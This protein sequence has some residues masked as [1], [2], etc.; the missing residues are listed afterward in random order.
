MAATKLK[1]VEPPKVVGEEEVK[2]LREDAVIPIH[3]V[4]VPDGPL[5]GRDNLLHVTIY[6]S[7]T[8]RRSW[9]IL[10]QNGASRAITLSKD[11]VAELAIGAIPVAQAMRE[12]IDFLSRFHGKRLPITGALEFWHLIHHMCAVTNEIPFVANPVDVNSFF[13]GAQGE[14]TKARVAWKKGPA[15]RLQQRLKLLEEAK[16]LAGELRW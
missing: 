5:P 2:V 7:E 14:V 3:F 1:L 15:R 6:H 8:L 11:I 16:N 4:I 10:P 12:I 9:N 13:A